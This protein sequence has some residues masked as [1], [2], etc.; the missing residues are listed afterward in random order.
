MGLNL[1]IIDLKT[2][3]MQLHV[4]R[5]L[6]K[7]QVVRYKGCVYMLTCLGFELNVAPKIMAAVIKFVLSSNPFEENATDSYEDD[8]FVDLNKV[9]SQEVLRVLGDFGL[10]AKPAEPLCGGRVLGLR[11]F[12]EKGVIKWKRDN[13][14]QE[15]SDEMTKR[16]VFSWCGQAIGHFPVA[17]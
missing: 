16:Q 14:L 9:S 13:T 8:I 1:C 4:S 11:V 10:Q 7:F 15:L 17:G 3:Y 2:A 6:W 5:E 12:K